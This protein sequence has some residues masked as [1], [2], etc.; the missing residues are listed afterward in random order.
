MKPHVDSQRM[1]RYKRFIIFVI[2]AKFFGFIQRTTGEKMKY[3]EK[4]ETSGLRK[5]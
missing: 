5:V 1:T 2:I 4:Q 3:E